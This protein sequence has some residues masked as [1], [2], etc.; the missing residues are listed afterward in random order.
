MF[1]QAYSGF[2]VELAGVG[3]LHAAFLNESRTRGC[4]WCPVQEIRIHRPKMGF[5]NAFTP[6]TTSLALRRSLFARVAEALEGAAP[7]KR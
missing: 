6:C 5:S 7:H 2:L 1:A 3:E 4:R